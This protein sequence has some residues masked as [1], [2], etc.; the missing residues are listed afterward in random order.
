MYYKILLQDFT[1]TLHAKTSWL[2]YMEPSSNDKIT[3]FNLDFIMGD[4]MTFSLWFDS[5]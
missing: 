5:N 2:K 3:K 4:I 1:P